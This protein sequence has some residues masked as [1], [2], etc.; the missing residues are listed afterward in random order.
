METRISEELPGC[1]SNGKML[2]HGCFLMYGCEPKK[3][4]T[5][6][7]SLTSQ[8]QTVENWR[9]KPQDL[10]KKR[11]VCRKIGA[12]TTD[13]ANKK[14]IT[15]VIEAVP[16]RSNRRFGDDVATLRDKIFMAEE[17]PTGVRGNARDN[18]ALMADSVT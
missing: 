6:G 10:G 14:R 16:T 1:V 2:V 3:C 15:P 18:V 11:G 9:P 4:R 7:F 13:S 8:N 12:N 5:S 17:D